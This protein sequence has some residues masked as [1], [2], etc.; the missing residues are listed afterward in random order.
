MKTFF[1]VLNIYIALIA[2]TSCDNP[3]TSEDKISSFSDSVKP[4]FITSKMLHKKYVENI[5][6]AD[7]SFKDSLLQ[8]TGRVIQID[9]NIDGDLLVYLM[10]TNENE[11]IE[12]LFSASHAAEVAKLKNGDV[13][14]FKGIC[15]GLESAFVRLNGCTITGVWPKIE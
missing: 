11:P 14:E 8:V 5:V 1:C 9:K 4:I 12:C 6:S 2:L 3:K 10:T 13:A 15:E 7:L